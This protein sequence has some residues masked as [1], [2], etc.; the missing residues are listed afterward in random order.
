MSQKLCLQWNDFKENVNIAFGSLRDNK[1]FSD[2]TLASE[3]GYQMEAHKVILASSSPFFQ[4]L[5]RR[6]KHPHP[7]VYLR[8]FQSHHLLAVLDF[9]YFGEAYVLQENIDPFL[10]IA[11][12]LKLKG[13]SGQNSEDLVDTKEKFKKS[14]PKEKA[15]ANLPHRVPKTTYED[16]VGEGLLLHKQLDDSE[17][18]A[19]A[20][21][22]HIPTD[23][24]ALDEKVKSLMIKSQNMIQVS[25]KKE[26]AMICKLC[27]KEGPNTNIKNHIEANHLEGLVIPCNLCDKVM[28]TRN[29]VATHKSTKHKNLK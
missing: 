11:E 4:D 3:D 13:L 9:L 28:N 19:S 20:I 12:E 6:N 21:T 23:L 1:D 29:A 24:V 16:P 15:K 8:G 25:S 5:L 22:G 7:L 26:F 14:M 18:K 27:Q 10:A 17:S 2:V